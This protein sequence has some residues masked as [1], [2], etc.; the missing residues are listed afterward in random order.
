MTT[1]SSIEPHI[2]DL[3]ARKGRR[4]ESLKNLSPREKVRQ[5]EELQARYY[6]L[7]RVRVANGGPAIP[8]GWQRWK[9]AQSSLKQTDK[10]GLVDR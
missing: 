4:R 5:L 6:E 2:A 8:E 10:E 3:Q 7:L 1:S 9:K